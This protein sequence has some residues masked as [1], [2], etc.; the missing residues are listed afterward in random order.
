MPKHRAEGRSGQGL[1]GTPGSTRP[2]EPRSCRGTLPSPREQTALRCQQRLRWHRSDSAERRRSCQLGSPRIDEAD[3]WMRIRV[4]RSVLSASPAAFRDQSFRGAP[5]RSRGR[6]ESRPE[7][8]ACPRT[9]PDSG[10]ARPPR[11]DRN[12]TQDQNRPLRSLR[13]SGVPTWSC[14]LGAVRSTPLRLGCTAS[15]GPLIAPCARS[16]VHLRWCKSSTPVPLGRSRLEM[17]V[18]VKAQDSEVSANS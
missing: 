1:G 6:D 11:S 18:K 2:S 7:R 3:P 14:R 13:L 16:S 5:G 8:P 15:H 9:A 10:P 17:Y 12:S 4:S